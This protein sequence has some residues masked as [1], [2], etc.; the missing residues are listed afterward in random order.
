MSPPPDAHLDALRSSVDRLRAVVAPLDDAQ[1]AAPAYPAEWSIAEVLSHVGSGA[2]IMQRQFDDARADQPTPD[3]FAPAVWEAW[4][5]KPDRTK[6]TD[7]LAADRA[8]LERLESSTGTE[9]ARLAFAMGPMTFDFVGFVA[10]RLNE[11]ALHTWDVEVALDAA[12]VVPAD[13]AALVVDNLELVARYTAEPSGTTRTVIV[14]TTD[15]ARQ[16]TVDV[17]ADSVSFTRGAGT[18]PSD[19]RLPAEAFV[20][21][22][23]GRL[24][25]DNTPAVDGDRS[26]LDELRHVFKGP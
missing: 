6:A 3:D 20:R 4:D 11:H 22:V 13:T 26:A 25:P 16:F 9:R 19:V 23:Y 7:A 2:A 17:R 14:S 10:L 1:L 5:A 12:A 24:D 21:L 18:S 15:P 8:L